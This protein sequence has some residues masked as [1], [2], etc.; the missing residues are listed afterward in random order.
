[1]IDKAI[2]QYPMIADKSKYPD[3]MNRLLAMCLV[4]Y[5]E[6]RFTPQP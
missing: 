3:A 1:M 5:T 4:A 2:A 6:T